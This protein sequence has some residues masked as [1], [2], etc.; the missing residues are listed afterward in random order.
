MKLKELLMLEYVDKN[1]TDLEKYLLSSTDERV[2]EVLEMIG[3]D[4]FV[5]WFIESDVERNANVNILYDYSDEQDE[6]EE[7]AEDGYLPRFK[8]NHPE[9][10]QEM[11][12]W[13]SDQISGNRL[14][15]GDYIWDVFDI[16]PEEKPSWKYLKA[17]E[18][19]KNQWLVHG[20]DKKN[21]LDIKRQGFIK[22]VDDLTK[23]G[24]TTWF[25]G[26]D[27]MKSRSGY[28]FAYTVDDFKRYGYNRYSSD[29]GLTYGNALVVF[30]ASGLRC[31]HKGDGEYQ[32]IFNGKTATDICP[33]HRL[34]SG[35]WA[36][37]G[38]NN[39]KLYMN[40]DL[41]QVVNWLDN[42]YA[43]YRKAIKWE[44]PK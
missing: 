44:K 4:R 23:L 43:Q 10:Y 28:N 7:D 32:T 29:W 1:I 42:N 27:D 25:S 41:V 26:D 39:K 36:I 6:I 38:E 15:G 11:Y 2:D 14:Y 37:I 21:L 17:E 24:L 8:K 19:V 40:K 31:W 3:I 16:P 34:D 20:T 12:D 18:I 5:P 30:R 33:V 9:F 35:E 13:V 22:G